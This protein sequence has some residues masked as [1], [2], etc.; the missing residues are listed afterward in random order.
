MQR[1]GLLNWNNI[2]YDKDFTAWLL[3]SLKQGIIEGFAI[4]WSGASAE[5]E[6]WKALIECTRTNGEKIM[7]F[8]E[9]TENV[10]VDM[11]G[12]KKVYIAVDQAKLD[13]GSSNAE[14]GTGVASIQTGASYP[15]S[16]Y[17]PL[18]SIASGTPTD[19]RQYFWLKQDLLN[20]TDLTNLI[21]NIVTTW[22]ITA[23]TFFGDWS[24]LTW[25]IVEVLS[26]I[27]T[28]IAWEDIIKWS[29]LYINTDWKAY[30]TDASNSNK[31]NFIWI[32]I[33]NTLSWW[34]IRVNIAWID[35]N[36]N[37]LNIWSLYYLQNAWYINIVDWTPIQNLT[38]W[39]TN[40]D[41]YF[42]YTW[43][44]KT[45][46]TFTTVTDFILRKIKLWIKKVWSP[47]W[48]VSCKLYASNFT[49]LIATSSTTFDISTFTTSFVDKE[50]TFA[51]I[52]LS[53]W[54]VY[55]LEISSSWTASTSNYWVVE[56]SWSNTYAGWVSYY[57][58]WSAWQNFSKD[59]YFVITMWTW[60]YINGTIWAIPW[61]NNVKVWKAVSSTELLLN[62]WAF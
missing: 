30:K 40:T 22:N 12:T 1:V 61:S 3:A 42:Q 41:S 6:P 18:Y 34:N 14:D 38:R 55:F 57:W 44:T 62:S 53:A 31:I 15:A 37:G 33:D 2:T 17:V 32:A 47:T 11:S 8:F 45:W 16:N 20:K 27:K 10:A 39:S 52:I 25:I 7:I 56:W 13:D 29:A 60:T 54:T 46:Q 9:N 4:S 51:D 24:W 26:T 43:I 50:F 58:N 19:E 48:T 35:N 5:I 49:T 23:N 21:N 59:K 36:L 28:F